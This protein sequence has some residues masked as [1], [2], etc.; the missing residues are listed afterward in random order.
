MKGKFQVL[1][2]RYQEWGDPAHQHSYKPAGAVSNYVHSLKLGDEMN[3]KLI[4]ANV[5]LQYVNN[6]VKGFPGVQT[7]TMI[8]VGAGLA[9]MVQALH[10]MLANAE[11]LT[12]IVFLYGNRTVSDILLKSQLDDWQEKFARK[13]KMVYVIGSRY[14]E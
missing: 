9:P 12:S 3:F 2:K 13:F 1:I 11:D 14:N 8:A 7:I 5:K 4:R 10:E 6:G